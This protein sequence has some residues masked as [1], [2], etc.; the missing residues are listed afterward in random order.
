MVIE[1]RLLHYADGSNPFGRRVLQVEVVGIETLADLIAIRDEI[2]GVATG[3]GAYLD[4]MRLYG[5]DRATFDIKEV[6]Y[7]DAIITRL[8]SLG[9]TGKI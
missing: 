9:W 8:K 5:S 1:K 3:S 2:K 4:A 7:K 6:W